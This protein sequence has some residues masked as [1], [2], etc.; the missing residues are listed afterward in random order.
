MPFFRRSASDREHCPGSRAPANTCRPRHRNRCPLL[1]GS[2]VAENVE[3]TEACR[4]DVAEE[5]EDGTCKRQFDNT[6]RGGKRLGFPR[7]L[8]LDSWRRLNGNRQPS[9]HCF[10]HVYTCAPG[11]RG[12]GWLAA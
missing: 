3:P 12:V 5:E 10:Q 6:D 11:P 9:T 2:A 7:R 1:T 8:D 4:R